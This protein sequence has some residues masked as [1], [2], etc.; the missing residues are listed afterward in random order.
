ME[1]TVTITVEAFQTMVERYTKAECDVEKYRDKWYAA[2]IRVDEL[3][4]KLKENEDGRS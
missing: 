2:K 1:N 4:A 3:E